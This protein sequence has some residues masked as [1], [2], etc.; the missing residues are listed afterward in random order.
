M[1]DINRTLPSPGSSLGWRRHAGPPLGPVAVVFALLFLGGLYPV[2]ILGGQPYFPG[3]WESAETIVTFFQTRAAA[4][5]LCA[6]FHFGAAIPLGI[7]TAAAASRLQFLGIQAAG[8]FIALFGG[9]AT[10]FNLFASAAMLWTLA[11]PG[12]ADDHALVQALYWLMT[13]FGGPGFS[14]P[15]GLLIAGVAVPAAF[16][17]VLPRWLVIVGLA[18]AA[19]GELSWLNLISERALFLVPLTRF[20]GF[21]WL[22]AA[23]FALPSTIDTA[24]GRPPRRE[25]RFPVP[26]GVEP[27]S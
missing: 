6:F 19:C 10:A 26:Q 7:F 25:G 11:H 14:V 13:A 1:N 3:P 20:P 23:G 8:T 16:T 15:L 24:T 22:I 17:R 2:T 27:R 9:F 4:V 21:V 18:V 5:L 12:V